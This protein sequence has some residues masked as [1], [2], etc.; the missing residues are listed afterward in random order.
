MLPLYAKFFLLTLF[1][2]AW[3]RPSKISFDEAPKN[4]LNNKL[5]L[6]NGR[7]LSE[8]DFSEDFKY[9][10][11]DSVATRA[12]EETDSIVSDFD[13][14]DNGYLS[15]Y[16]KEK[17]RK[18][19]RKSESDFED[20]SGSSDSLNSLSSK[21]KVLK[22]IIHHLN[23]SDKFNYDELKEYID[24]HLDGE[25]GEKLKLLVDELKKYKTKYF[26]MKSRLA[27]NIKKLRRR[28]KKHTMF[29]LLLVPSITSL[30]LLLWIIIPMVSAP[31]CAIACAPS[32]VVAAGS[33]GAAG[34]TGV[35]CASAAATSGVTS[36]GICGAAQLLAAS[37]TA[38]TTVATAA[39]VTTTTRFVLPPA[40][41]CGSFYRYMFSPLLLV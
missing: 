7:L 24:Q 19:K 34:A 11:G 1:V 17:I 22:E 15:I 20:L 33:S 40:F 2:W 35:A 16:L 30:I 37:P 25:Q 31:A 36:S 8:F 12:N 10:S 38:T 18:E 4:I 9:Y 3:H 23:K 29:I 21:K 26:Y 41:F 32:V 28:M 27:R 39:G 5:C 6:I 14:E 13:E